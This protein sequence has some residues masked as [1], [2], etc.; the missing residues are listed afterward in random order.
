MAVAW[1]SR[2]GCSAQHWPGEEDRTV[3]DPRIEAWLDSEAVQWTYEELVPLTD[4][5]AEA[6]KHN[7]ARVQAPI[8][9]DL[10]ERYT[11]ALIDGADLPAVI[12]KRRDKD[13][14]VVLIDGNQRLA[15]HVEAERT[16]IDC[17]L[18]HGTNDAK[19][20]AL[21]WTANKLNGDAGSALDRM[22]QAKHYHKLYP[23]FPSKEVARLF[24]IKE[25]TFSNSL[26]E[27]EV[28]QR[29]HDF[30]L[31]AD[32]INATNKHRLHTYIRSDVTFREAAKLCQEANL[33]GNQAQEFWADV[34]RA[35]T[36]TAV[37]DVIRAW[38]ER[39]DV[40]D[41]I[42]RKRLGRPRIPASKMQWALKNINSL[43]HHL[44]RNPDPS[45]L[46]V[47]GRAELLELLARYK[48]LGPLIN[49]LLKQFDEMTKAA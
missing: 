6:S 43:I 17:Y 5:D 24:G 32:A 40:Q 35:K 37:Q 1:R 38:R 2:D 14:M 25:S 11:L 33:V 42:R 9:E 7:Q 19:E 22:L 4:F 46:E 16:A 15:A 47:N 31:D 29:L 13:N 30:G 10:V 26:R 36:D 44:E 49:G 27:D 8:I 39:P 34:R 41:T 20:I 3:K 18:I 12:G 28:T 23:N 21:C 48:H 45:S